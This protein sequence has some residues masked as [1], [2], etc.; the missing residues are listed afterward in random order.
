[1][2]TYEIKGAPPAHVI[3][4]LGSDDLNPVVALL[5]FG[6]VYD[7]KGIPTRHEW[8]SSS[9]APLWFLEFDR[10]HKYSS[11]TAQYSAGSNKKCSWYKV[12]QLHDPY[13][14]ASRSIPSSYSH[15]VLKWP[16]YK[17][18]FAFRYLAEVRILSFTLIYR[19][20]S[21]MIYFFNIIAALY[22]V[23]RGMWLV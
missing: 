7:E 17:M 20:N 8:K 1:M 19:C 9:Q 22:V 4:A 16:L 15:V 11:E 12:Y 6:C 21:Y 10:D 2:Y 5:D 14:S 23:H 18:A 13:N 3:S